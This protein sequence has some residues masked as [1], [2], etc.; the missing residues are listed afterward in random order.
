MK[1]LSIKALSEQFLAQLG[2]ERQPPPEGAFT[3][4]EAAARSMRSEKT[5]LSMLTNDTRLESK[6]WRGRR[7]FWPKG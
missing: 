7:Y 6:L 3:V 5:T 4:R 2:D 1:K